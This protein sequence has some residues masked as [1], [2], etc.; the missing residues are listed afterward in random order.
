MP[1]ATLERARVLECTSPMVA[2][3]ALAV[4]AGLFTAAPITL[5]SGSVSLTGAGLLLL[6]IVLGAVGVHLAIRASRGQ[7]RSVAQA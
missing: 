2:C 4:F 3:A 7:L 5:S 1:L 6:T